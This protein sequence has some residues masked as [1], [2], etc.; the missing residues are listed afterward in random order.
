MS[1][2]PLGR[3]LSTNP[4]VNRDNEAHTTMAML[5]MRNLASQLLHPMPWKGVSAPGE[6]P[7]Q[8][9]F[10]DSRHYD[11]QSFRRPPTSRIRSPALYNSCGP[12]A[13][14]PY[15][16][17]SPPIP[18]RNGPGDRRK[19]IACDMPLEL[20]C[21]WLMNSLLH[22]SCSLGLACLLQLVPV[23]THRTH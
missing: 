23:W 5:E 3:N 1:A 18:A 16:C 9:G 15:E 6:E 12:K 19:L 21:L 7:R 4:K 13:L 14:V 2:L 17:H 20:D 22:M 10:E 11:P 8:V